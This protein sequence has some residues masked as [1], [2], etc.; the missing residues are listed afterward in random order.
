MSY[1]TPGAHIKEISLLPPNVSQVET[2]IPAFIGFT[3]KAE[4]EAPNDLLLEPTRIKSFQEYEL[5]FGGGNP[6]TFAASIDADNKVTLTTSPLDYPSFFMY[7]SLKMFFANGG[8]PCYIISVALYA[9]T[10]T[11]TMGD[12]LNKLAKEDAP[13]IIVF[14]DA[15]KLTSPNFYSLYTNALQQANDLKNR[16]VICDTFNGKK[17]DI[18]DDVINGTNGF[19][20]KIGIN[21]LKYGA[22]YFPDLI[23]T[24]NFSIDETTIDVTAGGSTD[25]LDTLKGGA[26]DKYYHLVKTAINKKYVNL[27]PS[28]TMAGIYAA[29]DKNR[30]VWKAPANVSLNNVVKPVVEIDRDMNDNMNDHVSGK[31]INA[32]RTFTDKGILVWGARTL[33]GNSGEWRYVSVRRFFTMVEISV[34]NASEQFVFEPNDSNTWIK[35]RA[36]IE[37]FLFLQWRAGALAGP[38]QEA[39]YFVRVGLGETMNATDINA[40]I[41]N[42][43][44]GIAA[45][46]PAEFIILKFSHKMQ[47]S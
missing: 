20:T 18:D 35:V 4:K 43:E 9:D 34:K 27:P 33:D 40:G 7:Y 19:R 22:T 8:G 42:I 30:G 44:I 10:S 2:A 15:R 21:N 28:S 37:N 41:M 23:T 45:V 31:S 24:L 11:G 29:V 1:K 13:T 17:S 6:E 12:G 36:M 32:I 38:T 3:E 46:R 26:N 25:K 47:E 14:P 5:F 16:F 39:A